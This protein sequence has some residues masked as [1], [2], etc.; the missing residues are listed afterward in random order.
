MQ[1]GINFKLLQKALKMSEKSFEKSY[2]KGSETKFY[3]KVFDV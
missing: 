2:G 1:I 3:F